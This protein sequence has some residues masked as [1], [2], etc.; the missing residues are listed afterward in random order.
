MNDKIYYVYIPTNKN[1]TVLYIG[2]TGNLRRRMY[3]HRNDINEGFTQKYNVHKLVYVE[4][5]RDAAIA[6]NREKQLNGWRRAK[7]EALINSKNPQWVD[8]S[9]NL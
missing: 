3:E 2:I 5:Y 4:R 7:K 1:N 9:E 8:L 6:I